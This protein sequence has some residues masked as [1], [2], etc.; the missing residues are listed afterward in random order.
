M[1]EVVFG[2]QVTGFLLQT[3]PV[4][5][6]YFMG[7]SE[8]YLQKPLAVCMKRFCR[9]VLFWAAGFGVAATIFYVL[10]INSYYMIPCN[11]YMLCFVFFFFWWSAGRIKMERGKKFIVLV[12][13]LQYEAVIVNLNTS[14]LEIPGMPLMYGYS[15]P[16]YLSNVLGLV[17]LNLIFFM[18]ALF[19]MKNVV[20]RNLP[21]IH[22][23][24]LKHGCFY[25]CASALVYLVVSTFINSLQYWAGAII[26]LAV[27]LCN[28]I[29]YLIYFSEISLVKQ[30]VQMEEQMQMVASRFELIQEN[31][32]TTR[33]ARHDMRHQL[34]AIR[35]FCEE[36]NMKGM[37]DFLEE[38]ENMLRELEQNGKKSGYPVLD[39]LLRYYIDYAEK[40]AVPV[41]C[42]VQVAKDH[43]FQIMD[44]TALVGN[45]VENA[46]EASQQLPEAERFLH[47]EIR[48]KDRHLL[49]QIENACPETP[50]SGRKKNRNP[51]A[52]H[53]I[54]LKSVQHV[55]EKYH[56]MVLYRQ[57]GPV[58]TIKVSLQIP[59]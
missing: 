3:V 19:L 4:A 57:D 12:L 1:I 18:P 40:R 25:V 10:D 8:E 45:C 58:F 53:G 30:Q 59:D 39:T 24:V 51:E 56:G 49:F 15:A 9:I 14:I 41:E 36:E 27:L 23:K 7:I 50:G 13:V 31:I 5:L 55:A 37:R 32:E 42:K 21:Y 28:V 35:A 16:F 17:F 44:I 22:G 6:L 20:R 11:L 52:G 46:V 26:L 48:E 2:L 47:I 43:S 33:R 38:N 54:G 29:S 34:N